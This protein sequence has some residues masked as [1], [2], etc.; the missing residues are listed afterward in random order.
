MRLIDGACVYSRRLP[1][2]WGRL[3]REAGKVVFNYRGFRPAARRGFTYSRLSG[4]SRLVLAPFGDGELLVDTSDQELGRLVF[5]TGGYERIYMEHALR[6]LEEVGASP[7]P[8]ST[9][10]DIGANIGTSTLD[11]ILHFGFTR[12]VSFEPEAA[13]HRL[14]KLNLV[15][16]GV[17]DRVDAHRLALSDHDGVGV[18]RLSQ[19]NLADHRVEEPTVS[20]DAAIAGS[21]QQIECGRLDS[22]VLAGKPPLDE[23]GLVWIDAQG[24]ELFVLRGAEQVTRAGVPVVMEYW[25]TGLAANGSAEALG[26]L[27]ADNYDVAIDLHRLA[28]G[29]R[30]EAILPTAALA[31]LHRR[32]PDGHTDLLL[33]A[34]RYRR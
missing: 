7:P 18:L 27:L 24:H 11:A 30:N 33:L 22:L 5:M 12:A 9:F 21:V 4:K 32:Y 13:S 14:L 10:V 23:I 29:L 17:E 15:L 25:P 2:R 16:N 3:V 8:G 6:Y 34:D 19:D 28:H 1:P 26:T 20:G 31:D